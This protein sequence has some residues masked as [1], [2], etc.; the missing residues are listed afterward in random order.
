VIFVQDNVLCNMQLKAGIPDSWILHESQSTI[1]VFFN[2]KMLTNIHDAMQDLTLHCNAGTTSISKKGDLKGYGTVWYHPDGIANILSLNNVKKKYKVIY[3]SGLDDGFV[4]HKGNGSQHVFKPS[5]KGLYCTDVT[6]DVRTTLVTTVDSNKNKYSVRQY[7]SA[8]KAHL[9]QST[10]GRPSTEDFI[11][12]VEGNMIPNCNITRDNIIQ[13]EDIFGPNL[14]SLKGKMTRRPTQHVNTSWTSVPQK[15]IQQYG[16]VT[17]AIDVIAI[18]KI[19]F[20][21]TTSRNIHFGTAKLKCNK[22][23]KTLMMSIQPVA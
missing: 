23:K 7:S 8:R 10:I 18:N 1:D 22:T 14:G 17:L 21:I 15:A 3:D 19:P 11:R 4:V 16:E 20:L 5:K 13:A 9:L 2:G 12:Y 6:N